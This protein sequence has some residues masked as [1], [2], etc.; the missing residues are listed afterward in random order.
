MEKSVS[1]EGRDLAVNRKDILRRNPD[2][3]WRRTNSEFVVLNTNTG[4]V[5]RSSV[6]GCRIY[7]LC[8][9]KKDVGRIV[10]QIESEFGL[11][12]NKVLQLVTAMQQR[13]LI[14]IWS[15]PTRNAKRGRR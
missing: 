2:V 14:E 12:G 11:G 4:V 15:P 3:M 7:K 5:T 8:D 13:S 6:V 1:R 9:G 10:R